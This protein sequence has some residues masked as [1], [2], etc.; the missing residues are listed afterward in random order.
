MADLPDPQQHMPGQEAH[1]HQL[2][3]RDF[4]EYALVIDARSPREYAEDHIPGAVSL[5]VVNDEEY[6][7]VGTLHRTDTHAAY[8]MGVAYSL[9]NIA[10]HIPALI[11]RFR[12][13]DRMLVYCFRGGKRSRLWADTLRTIGFRVDVLPGGWKAYRRWVRDSLETLPRKFEWRVLEGGTGVGKTRLLKALRA[14][15][16]QVI[17]LEGLAHHRGSLIGGIPGERQPTQKLFD[18]ALLD[19]LRQLD[20]TLPVWVEAESK[21]IGN[22]QLPTTLH[23]A[24]ANGKPLQIAAPLSERVRIWR[25]DFPHFALDPVAMVDK[26]EPLKPLVGGDELALWRQLAQAGCVDQLFERVMV[27]HYDP[28]YARSTRRARSVHAERHE[29]QLSSLA[30]DAL[31]IVARELA[32]RGT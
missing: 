18:S 11:A 20:V 29:L 5:P 23:E 9:Q 13:S 1:P 24:I 8:L 25:E 19:Q 6:A 2:D 27:H 30:D 7:Q 15:G 14:A 31:L 21:K 16:Q 10:A 26:L 4:S 3:V 12:P 17:D 32:A 22:L 28:C